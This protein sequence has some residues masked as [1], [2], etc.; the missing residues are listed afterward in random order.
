MTNAI[1]FR[2][3]AEMQE[4]RLFTHDDLNKLIPEGSQISAYTI[5]RHMRE[6][7]NVVISFK[8]ATK[9]TPA[10]W[11]IKPS[12]LAEYKKSPE[13]HIQNKVKQQEETSKKR[14]HSCIK[15][16]ANRRGNNFITETLIK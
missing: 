2:V 4:G 1:Y 7:L 5:I 8:H 15:G 12:D 14:D 3:L 10:Y 9:N 16:I 11:Y 13:K 6:Y